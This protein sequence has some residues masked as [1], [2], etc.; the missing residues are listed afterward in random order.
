MKGDKIMTGIYKITNKQTGESYVGK[1][2]DI[3]QRWASHERAL[4]NH[5]HHSTK[6]QND[7]DTYGGI[8]AFDFSVIEICSPSE[9]NELEQFY[10]N[11]FDTINNGYNGNKQNDCNERSE[12]TITN[13]AYKELQNRTGNS[14]LMT[15]LY[16]KFNADDRNQ[17]ILNQTQLAD[18]F[19]INVLTVSKHI[20]NLIEN[21]V[22]KGIGKSGLYNKYEILI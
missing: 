8:S 1:S 11:K 2:K 14:Y 7:F 17:I 18:D 22:I 9:L 12:I 16:L 5:T 6:L 19:G 4:L 20:K 10:I 15:Y 21:G 3:M 13:A